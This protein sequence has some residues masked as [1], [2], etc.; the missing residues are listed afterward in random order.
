MDPYRDPPDGHL[1]EVLWG[2]LDGALET[3]LV[4]PS[5]ALL[6]AGWIFMD[7][8]RWRLTDVM[9]ASEGLI[10]ALLDDLP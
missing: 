6:M 5:L 4:D 2:H 3:A 1:E 10:A 9:A 8:L 7:A